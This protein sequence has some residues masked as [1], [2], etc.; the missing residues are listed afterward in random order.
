MKPINN[1]LNVYAKKT[2]KFY[3]KSRKTLNKPRNKSR[4]YKLVLA[5][6]ATLFLVT[7][8]YAGFQA[9]NT[10]STD[11]NA[12]ILTQQF[13]KDAS[14]PA[15]VPGPHATLLIIPLVFIQGH[16]PYHYASFTI[17]NI[18]LILITMTAWAFLLIKLFG[19]KYEVPIL[20]FL[21]SL[22][23][24]SIAFSLSLGYT[25]IRNIEYPIVLWFVMIIS[26]LIKGREYTKKQLILPVIG[27]VLFSI[28]LAGDSFFNYAILLPLLVVIAWYWVQS[29]E[30]TVRMAKA[31]GLMVAVV[32]GAKALKFVLE[33]A[34]II[35]FDYTY[36]GPN[37]LLPTA[38]LWQSMAVALQQVLDLHGA[39]IFGKVVFYHNLSLFINFGLVIA[40]LVSMFF[41]LAEANQNYRIK[42][43]LGDDITNNSFVFT[44]MA[45]SYFVVFF[46]Y[47]LSGYAIATLPNGQIIDDHNARYISLMPL[48]SVIGLM[49][50]LKKYYPK[51]FAFQSILC[52]VL[53]LGIATSYTA[54][55]RTYADRSAQLELAPSRSTVDSLVD[56]LKQNNVKKVTADYWYGP[57]IRFWSNKTIGLAQQVGCAPPILAATASQ[58]THQ[59]GINT[60]LIIDRGG[61][62]YGYWTCTDDEIRA[63]F[64]EPTK[65]LQVP[66]A[67]A[68][69]QVNI[70]IY[71]N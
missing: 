19:R 50:L 26:G 8:I 12:I 54:I 64:G 27:S 17:V 29:K 16:L 5:L 69:T 25:T 68:G 6:S 62:N 4:I 18:G 31:I 32:I 2:Q 60:A 66:G 55:S 7:T 35:H 13:S 57:V 10:Y 15:I 40:G 22:I 38:K 70:W 44:V 14:Y 43:G 33:T 48:I 36:W 41:I 59:K 20:I 65:E 52:I 37:V 51:H 11:S 58:F 46:I 49:W 63:G 34:H 56:I 53:I 42:K 23:F 9:S 71:D 67:A 47:S 24:T 45:V 1:K 30:F 39:A 21:S 61:L 28:V 3:N